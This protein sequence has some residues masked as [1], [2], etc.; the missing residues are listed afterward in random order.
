M[1]TW[2]VR[3]TDFIERL[4]QLEDKVET[5]EAVMPRASDKGGGRAEVRSISEAEHLSRRLSQVQ[6]SL[7]KVKRVVLEKKEAD[8]CLLESRDDRLKSIDTDLQAIKRN[9]LLID[10]YESLAGRAGVLF[11]LY[12]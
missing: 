1:N 7:T 5:T 10:D 3:I 11:L 8:V 6:D 9:M 2:I 12:K 4:K